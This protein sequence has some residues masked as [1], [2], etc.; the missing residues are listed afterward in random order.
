MSFR[1]NI[2]TGVNECVSFGLVSMVGLI[3]LSVIILAQMLNLAPEVAPEVI[4]ISWAQIVILACAD[5]VGPLLRLALTLVFRL[6]DWTREELDAGRTNWTA[7]READVDS[8][9]VDVVGTIDPEHNHSSFRR[10]SE[11]KL[12]VSRI[13]ELSTVPTTAIPCHDLD[14]S[15]IRVTYDSTPVMLPNAHI[16]KKRSSSGLADPTEDPHARKDTWETP[17]FADFDENPFRDE[18]VPLAAELETVEPQKAA[19]I[20]GCREPRGVSHPSYAL[21]CC[22]FL[23]ALCIKC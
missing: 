10:A 19:E 8:R 11:T 1:G 13:L 5:A 4:L 22:D 20:L 15:T 17:K 6:L 14:Q 2:F 9:D 16:C 23:H 18:D 3:V 12:S 21:T 7:Q